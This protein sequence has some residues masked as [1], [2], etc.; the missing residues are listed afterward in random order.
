MR[1]IGFSTGPLPGGELADTIDRLSRSSAGAVELSGRRKK[2]LVPLLGALDRLDLTAFRHVSIHAPK[3]YK[4]PTEAEAARMLSVCIER[5]W[6]VVVHPDTIAVPAAWD[7]FGSLLA[8]ENMDG[9]KDLGRT[10]DEMR[11]VLER[12][13]RASICL[14]VAH[15]SH[16][17][18]SLELAS[19]LVAEFRSR[20]GQIHLS[21][22]DALGNHLPLRKSSAEYYRAV[23]RGVP[24]HVPVILETPVPMDHLAGQIDRALECFGE[25]SGEAIARDFHRALE[26]RLRERQ[27][28]L[29]AATRVHET[30]SGRDE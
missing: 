22:I 3:Q 4:N 9:R 28:A 24:E 1:P 16:I 19:R 30:A 27:R 17:D 20:L 11:A 13:P 25:G 15:A 8:V 10:V 23:L 18:P 21:E 5:G 12:F 29:R 14:D 26:A 7:A 2:A 6:P